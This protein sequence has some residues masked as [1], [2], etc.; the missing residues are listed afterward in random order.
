MSLK[1]KVEEVF[2][3]GQSITGEH[4]VYRVPG[5]PPRFYYY[6]LLP[7]R[8]KDGMENVMLLMEDVTDLVRLGE[9]ARRAERHLASVVESANDL[10]VSTDLKG[11]IVSWNT[12]AARAT[13]YEEAEVRLLN[14]ASLCPES[15][16]HDMSLILQRVPSGRTHR[17]GRARI[18]QPSGNAI[19]ISWVCSPMRD[20]E[21][22]ITGFVAVGRDLTERRKTAGTALPVRES[23][24]PWA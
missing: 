13:G 11:Q 1:S 21:A 4:M 23:S 10:V 3:T 20:E 6:S 2:R 14:I 19:P 22:N 16:R 7:F 12:A 9:E 17:A 18:A 8:W 15:S 24:R 5:V